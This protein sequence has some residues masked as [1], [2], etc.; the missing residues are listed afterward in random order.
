MRPSNPSASDPQLLSLRQRSLLLLLQA[1]CLILFFGPG[2]GAIILLVITL[3][4]QKA[5][6]ELHKHHNI[7]N[8]VL[9][10]T[11]YELVLLG[12][13][14][15]GFGLMAGVGY[16]LDWTYEDILRTTTALLLPVWM[17]FLII[18]LMELF[19][20]MIAVFVS[21]IRRQN[22][23]FPLTLELWPKK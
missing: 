18:K 19:L 17:L 11:L 2:L 1:S 7:E 5:Y 20:P 23:H 3:L 13:G 4:V 9:S 10:Y 8:Y 21:L 6:P 22:F 12:I 16:L 15:L 14:L